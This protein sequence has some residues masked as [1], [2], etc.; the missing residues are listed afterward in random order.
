MTLGLRHET[1]VRL[2]S[3]R[4]PA[5][6]RQAA[7]GLWYVTIYTLITIVAYVG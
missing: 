4:I 2:G 5:H 6:R 1:A 3:L 7:R